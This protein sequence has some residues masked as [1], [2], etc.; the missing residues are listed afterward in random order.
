LQD[1][2]TNVTRRSV[3]TQGKPMSVDGLLLATDEDEVSMT[4]K[5]LHVKTVLV[6]RPQF[7]AQVNLFAF[8]YLLYVAV[9]C[10]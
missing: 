1:H 3:G 8:F 9:A 6:V 10:P 7:T 4:R 2:T 5:M